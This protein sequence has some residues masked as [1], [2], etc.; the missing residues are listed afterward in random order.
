MTPRINLAGFY[1]NLGR[2]HDAYDALG[3][4]ASSGEGTSPYGRMQVDSV[5]LTIA[6]NGRR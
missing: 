2:S 1:A 4:M 5:L 3:S 6:T